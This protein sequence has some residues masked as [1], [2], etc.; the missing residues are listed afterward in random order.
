MV[1]PIATMHAPGAR[2]PGAIW[3]S[4]ATP[5][6]D[7]DGVI[8]ELLGLAAVDRYGLAPGDRYAFAKRFAACLRAERESASAYWLAAR[9]R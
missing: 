7:V 9:R 4:N 2:R 1:E 3:I 8:A 5:E 6:K